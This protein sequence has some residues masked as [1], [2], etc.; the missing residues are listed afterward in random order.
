MLLQAFLYGHNAHVPEPPV[1]K[2]IFFYNQE[3][4]VT[5]ELLIVSLHEG[6]GHD[7]YCSGNV[8]EML[9]S[10]V[11]SET[12]TVRLSSRP[13]MKIIYPDDQLFDEIEASVTLEDLSGHFGCHGSGYC[14]TDQESAE[15]LQANGRRYTSRMICIVVQKISPDSS[16]SSD[17]DDD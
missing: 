9:P 13:W 1:G 15:F 11:R 6:C 8:M 7:G 5:A 10:L 3:M 4:P 16:D 12:K 14:S 17:I 2:L